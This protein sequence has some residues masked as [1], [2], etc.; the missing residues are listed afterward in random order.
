LEASGIFK[1]LVEQAVATPGGLPWALLVGD[2]VFDGED[3]VDLLEK[4]AKVAAASGAPLISGAA[5]SV[6]G[7]GDPE[8]F[9]D[10]E[11][12]DE[13]PGAAWGRLRR[14]PEASSL[15]LLWPRF[16]LRL[17]YGSKTSPTEQ[18]QFEEAEFAWGHASY[19]WGNPAY[20]LAL[21][22]GQAFTQSGWHLRLGEVAEV[23]GLPVHV[24]EEDGE[25]TARPC[26]ELLLADRAIE[27]VAA[28]GLMPLVS[29]KGRDAVAL[30]RVQSLAGNPLRG[31]WES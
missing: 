12:W 18:F 17:P 20:V 11:D 25:P 10:V 23:N 7:C 2:Y 5:A 16:L 24:Y 3:D 8:R 6:V 21:L 9:P 27:H 14:T 15:G 30:G 26:G 13:S 28:R 22:A 29:I 4:V 1:L 19:L 31:R